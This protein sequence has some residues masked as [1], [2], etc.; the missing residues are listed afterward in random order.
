[1]HLI[2]W[3]WPLV[4]LGG[5]LAIA[6]GIYQA[7]TPKHFRLPHHKL[8]VAA[9]IAA[10]VLLGYPCVIAG[11]YSS[12]FVARHAD[13]GLAIALILLL[14]IPGLGFLVLFVFAGLMMETRSFKSSMHLFAPFAVIGGFF[15][16]AAW[17]VWDGD[18]SRL[19]S[20]RFYVAVAFITSITGLLVIAAY[21][22]SWRWSNVHPKLRVIY[23]VANAT[24]AL[25]AP[26]A[27]WFAID[28]IG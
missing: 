26:A 2:Q 21:V 28:A 7:R 5:A 13:S 22:T 10:S 16:A 23:I 17:G 20:S 1:M 6:N 18:P 15:V 4:L 12:T 11:A 25:V 14:G 19:L 27:V 24:L 9:A 3:R 8:E